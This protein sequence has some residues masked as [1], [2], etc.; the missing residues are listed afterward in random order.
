MA[1]L[2]VVQTVCK[3]VCSVTTV[4]KSVWNVTANKK[5]L[6][7]HSTRGCLHRSAKILALRLLNSVT[8]P[9][10]WLLLSEVWLRPVQQQS[11]QDLLLWCVFSRF[12]PRDFACSNQQPVRA[13]WSG[14]A[15]AWEHA[16]L[17]QIPGFGRKSLFALKIHYLVR[18]L[19]DRHLKYS[20]T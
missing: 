2:R 11:R 14:P 17:F 1:P 20:F 7:Q 13:S 8:V 9:C 4:C 15:V 3:R 16:E 12:K 19:G 10:H 5:Q 6:P 18:K